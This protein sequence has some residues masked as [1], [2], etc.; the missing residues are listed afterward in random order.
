MVNGGLCVDNSLEHAQ[1]I[2]VYP[3]KT[4]KDGKVDYF[5]FSVKQ[6]LNLTNK[7]LRVTEQKKN[8]GEILKRVLPFARKYKFELVV[9]MFRKFPEIINK[10]KDDEI[11]QFL[12]AEPDY[13]ADVL[14]FL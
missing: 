1:Y 3:N 11:M 13:C 4:L 9:N 14:E 5:Y 2:N 8:P 6:D 7:V 12:A 10:N